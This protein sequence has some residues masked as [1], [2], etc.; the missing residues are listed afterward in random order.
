MPTPSEDPLLVTLDVMASLNIGRG[1][2]DRLVAQGKLTPIRIG[3]RTAR[4]RTSQVEA[5]KL[6]AL[7][8][9]RLL[10]TEQV[11]TD[12]RAGRSTVEK[13]ISEGALLPIY[14]GSKR[15]RRIPESQVEALKTP[16]PAE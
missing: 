15:T 5:L 13:L 9:E 2:F 16:A 10:T 8:D 14:L 7:L 3:S 6:P 11:C 1:P 12:L 4:F